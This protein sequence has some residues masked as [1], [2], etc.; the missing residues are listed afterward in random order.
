[1]HF[2][3]SRMRNLNNNNNNHFFFFNLRSL[4]LNNFI[5][6]VV[7]FLSELKLFSLEPQLVT[8][9]EVLPLFLGIVT[10]ACLLTRGG[11]VGSSSRKSSLEYLDDFC[12]DFDPAAPA[13]K[14]LI[15]FFFRWGVKQ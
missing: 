15:S 8:C 1:M 2:Y 4:R 9:S 7:A 11:A 14:K 10:L 5:T 6:S 3:Q 12:R 13:K